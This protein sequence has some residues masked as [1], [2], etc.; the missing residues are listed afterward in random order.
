[1]LRPQSLNNTELEGQI[2]DTQHQE[3]FAK[4]GNLT[5]LDASSNNKVGNK[6]SSKQ[7]LLKKI[8]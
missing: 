4:I 2:T 5:L 6:W 1:M 8:V 3:F 7:M